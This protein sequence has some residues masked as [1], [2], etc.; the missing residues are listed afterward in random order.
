MRQLIARAYLHAPA[1]DPALGGIQLE[2]HQ[3]DAAARLLTL[4]AGHGGALL[5]DATGLGK[6]FVAIAV[7]RRYLRPLV[8]VPAAIRSMWQESLGRCRM[9]A[10][11]C[12]YDSLSRGGERSVTRPD[13]LILDEAHHARNPA[14]RRYAALADVA[15]GAD[16]LLL[17]ATPIHNRGRDLRALFAL[18]MGSCA[19]HK[20]IA[21][22]NR[23]IV[24]RTVAASSLGAESL[25]TVA[26]TRW[27]AIPPD[28]A[29]MHA[30]NAIPPAVPAGD[31]APAHAL[32]QLGLLRA[33][34]SSEAAL[35]ETLRRRLRRGA[36]FTAA[37]EEGR[38]PTR[39]ELA[40]WLFVDDAVQLGFP[41]LTAAGSLPDRDRI[42][43][44]SERHMDGV[45]S[46]L[47]QLD[48]NAGNG[49]RARVDAFVRIVRM[50]NDVP[51]VAF[52]QFADTAS[53]LFRATKHL[54]GVAL[55]SG[56]GGRVASGPVPESE[57]IRGF[58]LGDSRR[59][60]AMP[61]R[62]LIATDVLSEGLSLR[63][64]GVLVHFDLPWTVARLEQ[65]V[66]RLK[67]FGSPHR[68]IAV[69]AIGPPAST[70]ELIPALRA[71]QRKA[72]LSS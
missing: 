70:R 14:T 37:I 57:V 24:R 11:L 17:T 55:V 8:V 39:R 32:L 44:A 3:V 22:L 61:L 67:R 64:A 18:F 71:L 54:G 48:A 68:R 40:N 34:C 9:A 23:M 66:G 31:G 33:W 1:V 65:R 16:V 51:V 4:L 72:R 10:A 25:P 19:H 59:R 60:A 15:W 69:Y 20:E 6:T 43:A 52:S 58:D 35:R 38:V 13:L 53:W 49:D 29:T 27:I 45:R 50:H 36:A 28:P 5:A 26:R 63:R 42:R 30:I 41:Q 7:A 47:G 2:A 21:E 46:A 62:V 56:R 12:S